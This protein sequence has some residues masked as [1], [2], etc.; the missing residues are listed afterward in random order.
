MKK[1][2]SALLAACALI[3]PHLS[4]LLRLLPALLLWSLLSLE[5]TAAPASCPAGQRLVPSVDT[6]GWSVLSVTSSSL[7]SGAEVFD[8][9]VSTHWSSDQSGTLP[10]S[11]T[12]DMGTATAISG[13]WYYV[14]FDSA[15]EGPSQGQMTG[16]ELYVSDDN[17]TYTQVA[18][19]TLDTVDIIPKLISF[20][21]ETVRYFRLDI[22]GS[23]G[24]NYVN[25]SELSPVACGGVYNAQPISL[26]TCQSF[27]SLN[28]GLDLTTDAIYDP[29]KQFDHKWLVTA[30][31]PATD[32][33]AAALASVDAW[34]YSVAS[35]D[36]T[37]YRPGSYGGNWYNSF[38]DRADWISDSENGWHGSIANVDRLYRKDF[39]ID[40][41]NEFLNYLFSNLEFNFYADNSVHDILVNSTSLRSLPQYA[42]VLPSAPS[43]PYYSGG[44]TESS[45]VR[46]SI[47]AS[48]LQGGDN[49]IVVHLKSG[50]PVQGFF[51]ET[52][53]NLACSGVDLSDAPAGYGRALHGR[54]D[55]GLYLGTST[56][57]AETAFAD[58]AAADGDNSVGSNDE[59]GINGNLPPLTANAT[60]YNYS[61]TAA[62]FTGAAGTG[63]L[64]AWID[65]NNDGEFTAAEY[66]STTVTSGT[67]GNLDWSGITVAAPGTTFARFRLSS[68]TRLNSATPSG[69]ASDGE[70]EDYTVSIVDQDPDGDGLTNAQEALLGT[71]PEDADTDNDGISDGIEDANQNGVVDAGETSP[72]DADSD[73]DGLSDG[74]EDA[75]HNGTVDTGE[76]DPLNA[77]TDADGLQDGTELGMTAAITGG[78]STGT[79][80]VS[81]T[82]TDTGTFIPDADDSTTTDPLNPDT[83]GGGICDGSLAVSGTCEAGEDANNNGATDAGETDPNLGSDDPVDTDGDG[84]TDPVEALLGTDPED[85]DT[86]ND[87]I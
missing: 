84:L 32:D 2:G 35:G 52:D 14:D 20:A 54:T 9:D 39:T 75:N 4:F 57:D 21:T 59:D 18:S 44:Y 29:L 81:Y 80:P 40:T 79:N 55:P 46:L 25:I 17:S 33:T 85:A 63:T 31:P 66:A 67:I 78:S 61:L 51:A 41:S 56:P 3:P 47:D 30:I 1:P 37:G 77:D 65:F 5:A 82:G 6:S 26:A 23:K 72:L 83:D 36:V 74:A 15:S 73:D 87:G 49:S 27:D 48:L 42:S 12:I 8:G 62:N 7:G 19:G 86:D 71:D 68:D 13:L 28:T 10:Q 64:H 50:A 76:T 38:S 58:S 60:G 43:D 53:F 34:S 70:V 69:N 24:G 16:Y 45:K 22:L 11:I